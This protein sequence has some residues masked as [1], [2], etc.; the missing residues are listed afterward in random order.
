MYSETP[1]TNQKLCGREKIKRLNQNW[2][3]NDSVL[4]RNT[5]FN[6]R[7]VLMNYFNKIITVPDNWEIRNFVCNL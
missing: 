1:K 2:G 7:S 5:K 6:L 3:Y 4:S